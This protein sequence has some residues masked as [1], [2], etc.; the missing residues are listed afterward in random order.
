MLTV[1]VLCYLGLTIA[2]GLWAARR[3]HNA[4]DYIV[5]GRQLSLPVT[6]G[7]LFATWF[8]SE[9]VLGAAS[10][11]SAEGMLGAIED[12]LGAALCLFLIGSL[13]ARPLYRLNL[14][15]FGDYYRTR[16]NPTVELIASI[17]LVLS[18]LGWVAAQLVALGIIGNLLFHIPT[19]VGIIVGTI[20]VTIYTFWGGMWSVSILDFIQNLV[21]ILGMFAV[22]V[23]VS[24]H[25]AW[26]GIEKRL[27][28]HYFR[29][30][31]LKNTAVDWLNYI[32]AW[33]VV[34]LGSIPQQDVFQ[35]VMSAQSE[36][37]AVLAGY[38]GGFLYLT[39]GFLPLILATYVRAYHPEFMQGDSQFALFNL[40][41]KYASPP[42]QL[43]FLGALLSA[44]MSTAS[45]T[46]L[47]PAT[48]ISQNLIKPHIAF[49][50]KKLL[51]LSRVS[52]LFVALIS[53]GFALVQGNIHELA[54]QASALGLVSLYIPMAAGLYWKRANAA[55]AIGS[56]LIGLAAWGG[57]AFVETTLNPIWFGLVAGGLMM[58][59]GTILFPQKDS[60]DLS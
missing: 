57:A 35:R 54:L 29:F 45:G 18:Y 11:V 21:I 50:E 42:V 52:V 23:Q 43:L 22:T 32:A 48:I 59:A 2:I 31:P 49:G 27:P 44:V 34:G 12:P 55:G 1:G 28:E 46:L 26:T 9:T 10:K 17:C 37:T 24:E 36:R 15:T 41:E 30:I 20:L 16:Y 60:Q 5:A 53:L 13:F 51:M 19:E 7:A 4:Q 3:V 47:A 33:I 6:A 8:G 25:L 39:V 38:V 14:L 56:M 58:W 40:V